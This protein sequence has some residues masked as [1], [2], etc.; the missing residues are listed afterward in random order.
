MAQDPLAVANFFM[1]RR[2]PKTRIATS[3]PV[4]SYEGKANAGD[5]PACV[6]GALFVAAYAGVLHG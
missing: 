2:V 5:I 3:L 4:A 6:G 1:L